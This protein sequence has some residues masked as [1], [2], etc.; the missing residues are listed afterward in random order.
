MSASKYFTELRL[1]YGVYKRSLAANHYDETL[2]RIAVFWSHGGRAWT[3]GGY[4]HRI[5]QPPPPTPPPDTQ[6]LRVVHE[7]IIGFSHDLSDP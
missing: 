1:W 5:V 4:M 2:D 7:V 6:L 3:F